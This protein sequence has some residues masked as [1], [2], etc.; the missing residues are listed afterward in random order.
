MYTVGIAYHNNCTLHKHIQDHIEC[1]NRI[2]EVYDFLYKKGILN[3]LYIVKPIQIKDTT[4]KLCHSDDY[5]DH[6][7]NSL[8]TSKEYI[9]E[10]ECT[11]AIGVQTL[12]SIYTAVGC[13]C[14]ALHT[15]HESHIKKIYCNVRPPGHHASIDSTSGFCFVNNAAITALYALKHFVSIKKIAIFDWDLHH[16]NGTQNIIENHSNILYLSIHQNTFPYTGNDTYHGKFN[17]IFNYGFDKIN[18]KGYKKIFDDKIYTTIQQWDP[19]LIIISAG[20]DSHKNDVFRGFPLI[21]NDFYYM[22]VQLCKLADKYCDGRLISILEGG[23]DLS[24]LK[25]CVYSHINALLNYK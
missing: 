8:L 12:T 14:S 4:L 16:G 6:L 7:L 10:E 13:I 2:K 20:F 18:R 3:K 22:T 21:E 25:Q 23:Y 11:S 5:V 15:I 19:D 24:I 17:N 1:P 9:F